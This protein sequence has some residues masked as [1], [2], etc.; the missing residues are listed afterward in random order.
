MCIGF[1]ISNFPVHSPIKK[2][3]LFNRDETLPRPSLPLTKHEDGL[4]YGLDIPSQGTWLAFSPKKY[5]FLTNLDDMPFKPV[6]DPQFRRGRIVKG[7]LKGDSQLLTEAEF[8]EALEPF[9]KHR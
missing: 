2:I 3:I 5:A 6:T 8:E 1:I 9:I 4:F 7:A